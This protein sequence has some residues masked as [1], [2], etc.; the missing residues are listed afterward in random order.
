MKKLII[1]L[2]FWM[3][4]LS[5]CSMENFK[6]LWD[7]EKKNPE[8]WTTNETWKI[9]KKEETENKLV[10]FVWTY[11]PH[12]RTAVPVIE[13]FKTENESANIELMVVDNKPF[14][15][16]VKLK[17]NYTNPKYF[18]HYTSENCWYIP[19]YVFL[20]KDWAILKSKCWWTPSDVD[21][22]K[23]L[24]S[25]DEKKPEINEEKPENLTGDT[26]TNLT[27]N[28]DREMKD[29]KPTEVRLWDTVSVDYIWTFD[30]GTVFDTSIEQEAKK[31]N[32]YNEA[33]PYAP[34]TFTV[35]SWNMIKCFE[36]A[37]VWMKIW[38]TKD[39][40]CE[41]D[42]AYGQ[43]EEQR[44]VKVGREQLKSIEDQWVKIEKGLQIQSMQGAWTVAKV[45]WDEVTI[46]FNH[47]MCGKRLNFKIT[48]Q[49]IQE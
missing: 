17:Q 21:L 30:D 16:V 37:V 49:E 38:E 15:W 13:K 1:S 23:Y 2:L 45:E 26:N 25:T 12:C 22:K 36:K 47:P 46:D 18:N 10:M 32:T 9:T 29:G 44:M 27:N 39:I 8:S 35:G 40:K 28:K 43:C 3:F 4:L 11:C 19:A 20:D 33:R 48:V 31:S 42:D 24:I 7:E 34:L 14:P 6:Y 41:A 5:W